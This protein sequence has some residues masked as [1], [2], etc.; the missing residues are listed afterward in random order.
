MTQHAHTGSAVFAEQAR[1]LQTQ[2]A[3][4]SDDFNHAVELIHATQGKL[5]V[6]GMGKS[7]IIGRKI[8]A[9]F[10]S[11]GTSSFFVH[12]GEAF[13][14]DLGMISPQDSVLL[15]S[16]SGETE[17]V[18]R[19]LPYLKHIGAPVLAITGRG[20]STLAREADCVLLVPVE[21]EACPHNLAP[22]TST[23][24]TLVMGD[25]LAVALMELRQFQPTDFARFHPGGSLGRKLL[26][27]VRDVMTP[28]VPC[29]HPDDDFKQVV[30]HMTKG[31]LGLT[32]VLDD[33]GSLLG[34]ITDGDLRRGMERSDASDTLSA[35]QL[36]T[37]T[38]LTIPCDAMFADAEE[39][40]LKRK[41]TSLIAVDQHNR[42]AGIVKYFDL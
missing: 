13:H 37:P 10:A 39:L 20:D 6:C 30:N 26:T 1:A 11:T 25:A 17:E 24:L 36:M 38:P 41:I 12:P 5:V 27:R 7:G 28:T 19:L 32:V 29:N 8:A 9:T 3:R 35:R 33:D 2:A 22:T 40:M 16:N 18:L 15:L 14:G 23:T 31:C 34:I 42:P 21:R 4:L